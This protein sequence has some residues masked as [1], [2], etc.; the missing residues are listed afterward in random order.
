M[1]IMITA[2]MLITMIGQVAA[3]ETKGEEIGKTKRTKVKFDK[4]TTEE[5]RNFQITM[6]QEFGVVDFVEAWN[7][8]IKIPGT[9]Q[10]QGGDEI[11]YAIID[12]TINLKK[13]VD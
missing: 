1:K 13:L 3:S 11:W 12:T 10:E 2:L 5:V 9:F 8:I 4:M 7:K 6:A